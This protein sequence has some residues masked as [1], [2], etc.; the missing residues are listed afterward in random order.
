MTF[1]NFGAL[2]GL[3]AI[4]IPI[5]IHLLNKMQVKEVHWAAMRFLLESMQ[6]NQ[7][8]LQMEDLLLLL[9]R[10]LLVALLILALSRP[11]LQTGARSSGSHV[12]TA[13]I[14]IDNSY[15]MGLSDGIT[16]SFQRA[17]GFR[18]A[19]PQR[20]F[21]PRTTSRLPL[22]S[23]PLTSISCARPSARPSLRIVPPTSV[24]RCKAP[25]QPCKSRVTAHPRKFT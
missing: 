17:Q 11:T 18:Q 6:K 21:L 12:V 23:R 14:I 7:R 20:S 4:C 19:R 3:A 5:I 2:F 22:P 15:S 8:R 13:V 25:L 9:L 16:T 10:C 1:L 24:S